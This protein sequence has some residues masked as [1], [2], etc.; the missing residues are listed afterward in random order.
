MAELPNIVEMIAAVAIVG[1]GTLLQGTVG[2]GAALV[3]APLLAL[4]NPIFVPGPMIICGFTMA[5]LMTLREHES[6]HLSGVAWALTGRL[7]GTVIGAAAL[8]LI[9]K[10]AMG[11]VFGAL[12]LIAVALSAS[13]IH[14]RPTRNALLGAGLVSG[15]MGTTSSI[16]GPPLALIYQHSEGP[17]IRATLAGYFIFSSTMSL[18]ALAL[19]GRLGATELGAA[20]PLIPGVVIGYALSARTAPILDRG[21]TRPMVIAVS[22]AAGLTVI[23]KQIF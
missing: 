2:F 9:P 20:L 7:P 8:V 16:G 14:L 3:A 18:T 5:L 6:I 22:A 23:L 4:I 19:I 15:I 1:A 13:G 10:D 12:V 21:Y 17:T 11:L